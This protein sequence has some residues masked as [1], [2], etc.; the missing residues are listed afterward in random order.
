MEYL[1]FWIGSIFVSMGMEIYNSLRI[2]KDVA[3]QGYK[4]DREE[5]NMQ[6]GHFD[7]DFFR[8][9]VPF[10]PVI[11]LMNAMKNSMI[12]INQK[13][14]LIDQLSVLH[15]IEKMSDFEKKIYSKKP[16]MGNAFM[17]SNNLSKPLSFLTFD[18]DGKSRVI[19]FKKR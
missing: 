18:K 1:V 12:Y 7:N 2:Y 3:D 8:K 13:D 9:V 10:V 19:Q 14:M 17:I 4:I 6:I 15:S 16:T 5:L 11:N